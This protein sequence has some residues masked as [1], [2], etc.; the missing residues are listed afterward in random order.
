MT[1]NELPAL[2]HHMAKVISQILNH[3]IRSTFLKV[4]HS[5][6]HFTDPF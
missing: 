2:M 6:D 4:V 5:G 1:N 3:H